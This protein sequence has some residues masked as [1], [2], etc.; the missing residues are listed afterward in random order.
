MSLKI[1]HSKDNDHEISVWRKDFW[2]TDDN[3]II[4]NNI[5]YYNSLV[6]FSNWDTPWEKFVFNQSKFNWRD[7]PPNL[8]QVNL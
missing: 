6:Q 2:I 4:S 8:S 7:C 1:N 5:Q 3:Q